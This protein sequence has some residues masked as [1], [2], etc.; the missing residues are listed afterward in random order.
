[1]SPAHGM[2]AM[3]LAVLVLELVLV[4]LVHTCGECKHEGNRARTVLKS[5]DLR[6]RAERVR[7][8]GRR[9]EERGR[10]ERAG[11]ERGGRGEERGG[12]GR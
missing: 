7:G 1:M 3:Y 2:R 11:K 9:E 12:K 10:E 8:E 4:L 5:R 6:V